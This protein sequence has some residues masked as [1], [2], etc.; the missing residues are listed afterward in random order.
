MFCTGDIYWYGESLT[1]NEITFHFADSK[2]ITQRG[3]ARSAIPHVSEKT[4]S[5]LESCY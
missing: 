4:I 2:K 3:G 1:T 5:K